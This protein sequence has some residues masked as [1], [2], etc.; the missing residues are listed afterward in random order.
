[1]YIVTGGAGMIGS[2]MVWQLNSLGIDDIWVVDNLGSSE[3]W[4]NL[5]NR[6]FTEYLPRETFL[7]LVQR[8]A[9]PGGIEA[10]FHM[11]A[12]SSTTERDVDYL[13]RNNL[14]Y[15]KTLASYAAQKDIRLIVA[16]SA[17]TYGD[18]D[19]GFDDASDKLDS[20]K[21]LN[22]YGYSK[23]LFDLWAKRTGM[24]TKMASLKF[25]NVYG[26]NEY[27]KGDMRSVVAKAFVRIRKT[28][29]MQLFASDRADY[30]DG[31]Q[32]R[33]FIYVKDC[34][35]VMWWLA[36]HPQVN[37]LFNLGTGQARTWNA[38]AKSLFAAM[39]KDWSVEYTPLPEQLR[40]KYQY[41]TE[42]KMDKLAATGCP[43]SAWPLE[44]GVAD[45]VQNY[46]IQDDPHL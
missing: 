44:K 33:D 29:G 30:G 41:F 28:D 39:D 46:L 40:G 16:S 10:I 31:E 25:F 36:Q 38:L 34:T 9:L 20:L 11:G 24:Q 6:R 7:D 4:K 18:G 43:P 17:A 3:K 35:A 12:C 2:A 14:E 32:M 45:Y 13:F 15:S 1:M 21:P 23:H 27:Y 22:A 19:Q 5:V 8:D 26:P 42:A 37:G